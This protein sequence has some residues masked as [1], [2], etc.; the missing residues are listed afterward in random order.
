MFCKFCG[1]TIPDG[2]AFCKFCGNQTS[3]G[4][5][6]ASQEVMLVPCPKCGMSIPSG[7][8]FCRYCGSSTEVRARNY[9]AVTIIL[10]VLLAALIGV[11]VWKIPA[12][13]ET[14]FESSGT[15]EST[16]GRKGAKGEE[17]ETGDTG[18]YAPADTFESVDAALAD[19]SLFEGVDTSGPHPEYG[20]LFGDEG[21][22][23]ITE[24]EETQEEEK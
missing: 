23:D 11:G 1:K 19:G 20:W 10:A 16:S 3:R 12:N 22:W 6:S 4:A 8:V 9:T 13:V 18:S 24:D 5:A 14:L 17:A 15:S 7:A 2:A 21:G